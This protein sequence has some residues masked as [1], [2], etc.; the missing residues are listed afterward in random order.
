MQKMMY[1]IF[2]FICL[3]KNEYQSKNTKH[4]NSSVII[5]LRDELLN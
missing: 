5:Y 4:F 1:D 2:D 3:L